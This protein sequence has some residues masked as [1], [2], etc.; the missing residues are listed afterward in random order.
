MPYAARDR[1]WKIRD[2]SEKVLTEEITGSGCNMCEEGGGFWEIIGGWGN[3]FVRDYREA[4]G[5]EEQGI[6]E[7]P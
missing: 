3:S 6:R 1:I 5:S 4:N 2:G 7:V